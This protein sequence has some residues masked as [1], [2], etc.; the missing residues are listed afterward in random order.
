MSD[1]YLRI[2]FE[3]LE[4][5]N[6]S[7]A[8]TLSGQRVADFEKHCPCCDEMNS[9]RFQLPCQYYGTLVVLVT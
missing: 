5:R 3:G 9:F 7:A 8:V 2:L 1:L 6:C 4:E